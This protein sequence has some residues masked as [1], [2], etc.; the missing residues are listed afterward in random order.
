MTYPDPTLFG[1]D[2]WWLILLKAARHLRLPDAVLVG[3]DPA[4]AQDPRLHADA[5]GPE[6]RRTVGTAA[7]TGRRRQAGPQR[8]PHPRRCGQV[9]LP[10]GAGHLRGSRV[11][12][13][14]R[15]PDGRRGVDLRTPH[16]TAAD[17]YARRGAVRARRDVDRGVRNRVG[18]LGFRFHLSAAGWSAVERPGDLLRDRDGPVVRRGLHLRG[19]DVDLGHRRLAGGPL[20][21]LPAAAVVHHLSHVDGRRNQPGAFRS[22]RGR[23]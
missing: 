15:D 10:C 1:H 20:V 19:H 18:G 2:P 17:R 5:P 16:R 13:V 4:R 7:I 3:G 12:R 22:A 6:P 8:G 23:G 14:L 11:H 9:H 21:H